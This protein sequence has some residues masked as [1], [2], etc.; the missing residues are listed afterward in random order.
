M[1]YNQGC[2]GY[3]KNIVPVNRT[4]RNERGRASFEGRV[5]ALERTR[6]MPIKRDEHGLTPKQAQFVSEYVKDW[7][8]TN[9]GRRM[10]IKPAATY[11][12]LRC[13]AV[14]ARL[15]QIKTDMDKSAVAT[16]E[17]VAAYL[18]AVLRGEETEAVLRGCGVGMQTEIRQQVKAKDRLKAAE[19]LGKHYSM[20]TDKV[21]HSG[22]LPVVI[23]DDLAN[24]N[25]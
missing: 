22:N 1:F 13:P 2:F 16:A 8:V 25:G 11:R 18:T 19:L 4:H 6:R 21:E 17:E 5:F 20:F 23:V 3:T 14:A 15:E 24:D 12:Y 9:A 10:G 7:N